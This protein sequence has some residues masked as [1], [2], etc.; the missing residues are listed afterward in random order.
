MPSRDRRAGGRRPYRLRKR[1]DQQDQTRLR[2]IEALVELHRTVG[3]ARTT[4]TEV[5]ELAGVGRMTVYNHFPTEAEMLGA[6]SA[7]WAALH[8]PPDTEA[9][10]QVADPAE[11]LRTALGEMYAYYRSN[12]DMLGKVLRDELLLPALA[13]VMA[14][15]WWPTIEGMVACLARGRGLRGRR[16]DRLE[17]ALR[18]MLDF[19]TWRR[20]ADA[21]DDEEAAKL[22]AEMVEAAA[23]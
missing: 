2:I 17:A 19:T 22:A 7:H 18:L 5:A 9:W 21:L 13:E 10:L 12:E 6:C 16:R 8:P 15:A 11:R 23:A 3:P 4:V 1:A 14:D 20:L